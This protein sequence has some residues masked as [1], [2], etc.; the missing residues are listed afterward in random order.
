MVTLHTLLQA[1]SIPVGDWEDLP[2]SAVVQ[3]S[4]HAKAGALFFA[5]DGNHT[6][7]RSW[8]SEAVAK[9]AVA[10]IAERAIEELSVPVIVVAQ[11]RSVY[12]RMCAAFHGDPQEK[13][14]IIGVTGTDGKSTTCHY[15]HQIMARIGIRSGLLST[16]SLDD[17]SKAG[18]SPYRQSTPEAEALFAF[19]ARCS[20]HGLSHVILECTSHALSAAF[21]RLGPITF[22]AAVVTTV[23]REHLDFHRTPAAY[24]DAKMNLVRRLKMNGLFV[25]SIENAALDAFISHLDPSIEPIIVGQSLPYHIDANGWEGVII[26]AEGKRVQTGL[27]LSVLATNALLALVTARRMCEPPIDLSILSALK[28]VKGRMERVPNDLGIIA[29]IDFAHTPDSYEKLFSFVSTIH[30][31]GRL[32]VVMGAAGERDR[33]KR[34]AM[35][36]I[37]S[38]QADLL[39]I[40]E[41][42]PRGEDEAQ[43]A[44]D[45]LKEVEEGHGPIIT[46]PRRRSAIARAVREAGSGDVILF[47]GKGHERSIQ[48]REGTIAWDER[49]VVRAALRKKERTLCR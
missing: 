43:I 35:G 21:D 28:G 25:S 31:T 2:I 33:S 48:R 7:G 13:L 40:T 45:L 32:I 42:D 39:I 29:C 46:I 4:N 1:C 15:L 16:T 37:A 38:A 11:I 27:L 44:A 10:V 17:G 34:A 12:S 24:L 22:D 19:L 30:S 41:E 26:E 20:A 23:S 5:F 36:R 18:A 49:E 6:S 3:H 8:A 14:T 9:G 47:L